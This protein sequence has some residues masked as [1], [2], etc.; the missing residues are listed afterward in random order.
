VQDRIRLRQQGF[1]DLVLDLSCALHHVRVR[2]TPW[3]P[4]VYAG[5]T[6][7]GSASRPAIPPAHRGWVH[8]VRALACAYRCAPLEGFFP[9]RANGSYHILTEES[10][11]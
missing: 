9:Y 8:T 7:V 1:R 5:Y 11:K 2:L 4:P 6:H 10:E 3:Q